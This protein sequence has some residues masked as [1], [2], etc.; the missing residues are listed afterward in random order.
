LIN[1]VIFKEFCLFCN[2][3]C[4]FLPRLID[5]SNSFLQ[6]LATLFPLGILAIHS[7]TGQRFNILFQIGKR[8]FPVTVSDAEVANQSIGPAA[9]LETQISN[10]LI[11][12]LCIFAGSA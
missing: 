9:V 7:K 4:H 1:D 8:M 10:G 2:K 12:V 3:L 5:R 6:I 11:V